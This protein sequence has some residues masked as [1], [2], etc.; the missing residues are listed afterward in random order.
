MG[1]ITVFIILFAYSFASVPDY[2][3]IFGSDFDSALHFFD[4]NKVKI[5]KLTTQY[6]VSESILSSVLFPEKIRYSIFQDYFETQALSI[7]YVDLGSNLVDFSIGD[8]QMK[9]SFIELL[10]TLLLLDDQL[11]M[12]YY[13]LAYTQK[14]DKNK[15][16][17]RIKRLKSLD[18]QI[19]YACLFLDICSKAHD[20]SNLND[21]EK[22]K[23]YASAYNHGFWYP[24][25]EIMDYAQKTF[26]PYGKSYPYKQYAYAD[27]ALYYYLNYTN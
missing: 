2:K 23:F 19:I 15:R 24:V 27:V 22:I 20:L 26:F 3:K 4:N 1:K 21:N 9:V 8:F 11:M 7:S 13:T 5:K 10:D 25:Q 12:K 14:G 16:L 6:Q 18:Y 17:E